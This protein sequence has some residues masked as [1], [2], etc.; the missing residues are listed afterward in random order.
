[1]SQWWCGCCSC[2][3]PYADEGDCSGRHPKP[4]S[5]HQQDLM[6]EY[7]ANQPRTIFTIQFTPNAFNRPW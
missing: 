1:M 3:G 5:F 4:C 2:C 7:E 6:A